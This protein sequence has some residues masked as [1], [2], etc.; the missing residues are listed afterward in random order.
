MCELCDKQTGAFS[1]RQALLGTGAVLASAT[2]GALPL[3]AEQPSSAP[4]A[5]PPAQAL[6]KLMQGNA[7][8]AAGEPDFSAAETTQ[9]EVRSP[10]AAILAC[11]DSPAPAEIIF[12]QAPGDLFIVRV[13]GNIV[14]TDG[15]AS[16][17]Y[18]V[19]RHGVP[20]L[21]V[22]GHSNCGTVAEA[23]AATRMRKELPGHIG[24]LIKSIEPAVIAAHGRHPSDFLAATIEENVRLSMKRLMQES[25]IIAQTLAKKT[26]AVSGGVYDLSSGTVKLV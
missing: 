17:E 9:S 12:D 23:L 10:I 7:R 22:L 25:E 14:D 20:L 3:Q 21:M 4:N 1:R 6:E 26:L 11:S 24:A 15:L 19:E 18:A 13:A 16:F 5:I 8:F 2:L